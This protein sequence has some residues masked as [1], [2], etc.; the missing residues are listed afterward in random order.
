LEA[1]Q[2]LP[3]VSPYEDPSDINRNSDISEKC[4][5][6]VLHELFSLFVTCSAERRRLLCLKQHLGLP[7]KL[8]RVF[9][10]HPHVFYLLLKEKT[11]FVVLKEAYMAGEDMAVEKHLIL[12]VHKKYVELMEAGDH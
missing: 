5:I 4:V 7:Q 2:K 8:D 1:F 11:C 3:Y 6:A 12:E 9:E 10:W